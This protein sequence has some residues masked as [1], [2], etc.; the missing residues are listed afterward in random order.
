MDGPM[1]ELE[2]TNNDRKSRRALLLLVMCVGTTGLAGYLHGGDGASTATSAQSSPEQTIERSANR[3]ASLFAA[4]YGALQKSCT[5]MTQPAC[6]RMNCERISGPI[7][8]CT[9]P[10]R[11]F[12]KSFENAKVRAIVIRG[13]NAAAMFSNGEAVELHHVR[14]PDPRRLNTWWVHKFGETA[15]DAMFVTMVGNKW[16][17]LFAKDDPAACDHLFGQPLCEQYWGK[18][19]GARSE[20]GHPTALQK[21]FANATVERVRVARHKAAAEFS[22]GEIVEFVQET[23]T[24][25]P[26]LGRL[27]DWFVHSIGRREAVAST[28]AAT[29]HVG[30]I[31]LP[32]KDASPSTP[33][34]GK[35][36]AF[37]WA[38]MA[39]DW[40]KSRLWLFADGRLI[41]LREADIPEGANPRSTGFLEQRLTPQGVE[42]LRSR[43]RR[44]DLSQL[45]KHAWA[46]QRI[47]AYVPSSY[48]VCYDQGD[49][50]ALGHTQLAGG[51]ERL[52]SLVPARARDVLRGNEVDAAHSKVPNVYC[53]T[54]TTQKARVLA[55]ALGT[56]WFERGQ[57]SRDF[58][59]SYESKRLDPRHPSREPVVLSFEPI[60]PHGEWTCSPCG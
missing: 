22:N 56:A 1:E 51:Y 10:P 43:T 17:P 23:D 41:T 32:S 45:P 19:G 20:A 58:V 11:K 24:R 9:R 21:S 8:N 46:D 26:L 48:A 37:W 30:F 59:L 4:N 60:L 13:Q 25:D 35:L 7:K 12:R 42:M 55:A 47:R 44:P 28:A 34:R 16:A 2:M 15:G 6:E 49:G 36:V 52:W 29:G 27:G 33:R 40:G 39:G 54:L 50:G 53:W 18:P 5:L 3:W 38:S 57:R 31:G 14:S